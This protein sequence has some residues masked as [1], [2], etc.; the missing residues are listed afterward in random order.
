[1]SRSVFRKL[2][3]A[4]MPPRLFSLVVSVLLVTTPAVVIRLQH[5]NR[6]ATLINLS[7]STVIVSNSSG[8]FRKIL[9]AREAAEFCAIAGIDPAKRVAVYA[10]SP[11]SMQSKSKIAVRAPATLPAGTPVKVTFLYGQDGRLTVQATLPAAGREARLTLARAS[12]MSDEEI[13]KLADG[14]VFERVVPAPARVTGRR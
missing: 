9:S 7:G 14:V 8:Q 6:E 1:M 5:S 11:F 10:L 3:A 4:T 2:T 12:G 13:A